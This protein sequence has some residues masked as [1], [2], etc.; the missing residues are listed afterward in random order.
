[1]GREPVTVIVTVR[2]EEASIDALLVS[3][4]SGT[5]APDEIVV[6]DGGSTDR[7]VERLRARADSD[8]R[9]RYLLAPG[10]RSVGRNA[11]I[12]A[13]RFDVIACTDAGAEAEPNWLERITAPFEADS[14]VDVVAGFYR[15]AGDTWFERAAGVVSAPRLRDVDPAKFLPSTR[16]VA[17][18]RRA[19][20]AA[21]GFDERLDHNEDTPFALA[22]RK[23]GCRFAFAPD[24]IVRWKPRATLR[25]FYRQHWRFGYGDGESGVQSWFYGTIATKYAIACDLLILGFWLRPA[26]WALAA[27][28]V[29]FVV[30]QAWRG[31]GRVPAW[32]A[33]VAVPALKVVYDVAYLHGYVMGTAQ[34]MA[35]RMGAAAE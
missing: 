1:V 32:S 11:A 29:L 16:S 8:A 22:L 12:R 26:W 19:W 25:A 33:L 3:L 20:E 21:G 5:R 10:N 17:F 15:A 14:S 18:R 27:G 13:A 2:N 23:A 9:V 30:A 6:G 28:V 31:W 24:A 7:T 34:R 4:L 35:R